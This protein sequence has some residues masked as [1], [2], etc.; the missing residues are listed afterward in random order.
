MKVQETFKTSD[1][2]QFG[3]VDNGCYWEIHFVDGNNSVEIF[4]F[5]KDHPD[6]AKYSSIM[7]ELAKGYT[8]SLNAVGA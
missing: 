3:I 4:P 7:D 8:A 1:G 2:R 6:E 5:L